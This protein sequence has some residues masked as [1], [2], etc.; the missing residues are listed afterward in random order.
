MN[1]AGVVDYIVVGAGSAGCAVASRL[2]ESGKYSVALLE[3]GGSDWNFWVQ[4]PIGYG[5]AFFDKKLNW[6]YE[7]EP[8]PTLNDRVSYC[9]RGRVLGGSSSIN[10]MVYI[11]GH[12]GDFDDWASMGNAGWGWSVVL[13]YFRKMETDLAKGGDLRGGNGPV[14]VSG[15]NGNEHK[16]CHDFIQAGLEFGLSENGDFNGESLMG[17]GLYQYTISGGRRM[18]AARAY[19]RAARRRSNFR[20]I[21]NALTQK[22]IFEGGKAVGVYFQKNGH[23]HEIKAAK[24]I[25]LSAGAINTPQLLMLS[26]VGDE[27]HL[28]EMN[29]PVQHDLPGVGQHLQDHLCLDFLYKAKVPTL[30]NE[31]RPWS[32]RFLAA[33]KYAL[34]RS[35][36]LALGVN[37]AGGFLKSAPDLTRPD[38]QLFFSP[39]SYTKA[40]EGERPLMSPDPFPGFLLSIQPTKPKSRGYI[41]LNSRDPEQAPKIFPKYLSHP[42]D[43]E[44]LMKG[45][46]IIR[47]FSRMPSLAAIIEKELEPGDGVQ[48]DHQLEEDIRNRA[49]SVYHPVGSCRMGPD[50]RLDV[51]DNHLKVY[52][53]TG[54]RVVDAS[55]FPTLTSGNTNAPAIMVGEKAADLILADVERLDAPR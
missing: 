32:G 16:T 45:A 36:S 47:E 29:I 55:I 46:R 2:S 9:P 6:M 13:P 22:I 38:M 18:S 14:A 8:E 12:Q 21:T 17:V 10:A 31:L 41:S 50:P 33:V 5:K 11:R 39:L 19:L 54:L 26:G 23:E 51:V 37:Q 28:R 35:G 49:C 1:D 34:A 53:V 3:A 25:I 30:N 48:T 44:N 27:K 4:M 42:D 20:V 52:G 15:A 7:T 43:L 40:P 24:E